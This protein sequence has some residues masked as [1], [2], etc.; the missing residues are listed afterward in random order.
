MTRVSALSLHQNER[1]RLLAWRRAWAHE[2]LKEGKIQLAHQYFGAALKALHE[3]EV[4]I[5]GH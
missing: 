3:A 5:R 2:C 1:L 4:E